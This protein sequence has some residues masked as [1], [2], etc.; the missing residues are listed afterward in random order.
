M[1]TPDRGVQAG[2]QQE[3]VHSR[4]PLQQGHARIGPLHRQ[5]L[6]RGDP[7]LR[8]GHFIAKDMTDGAGPDALEGRDVEAIGLD[9]MTGRV[10]LPIRHDHGR[11]AAADPVGSNGDGIEEVTGT[12]S[13]DLRIVAHRPGEHDRHAPRP[14]IER[15]IKP[16]GRFLQRIRPMRDDDAIG[17]G[18]ECRID[19]LAQF[20]HEGRGHI[21]AR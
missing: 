21:E 9:D 13:T 19:R 4:G 3:V 12:V 16:E 8:I 10:N 14:D 7:T 15:Q 5:R 17:A 6:P 11:K 2:P 1:T 20:E 18:I